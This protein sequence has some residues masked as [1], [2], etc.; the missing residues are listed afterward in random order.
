LEKSEW[1]EWEIRL[2]LSELFE[3]EGLNRGVRAGGSR[4]ELDET[5]K[6]GRIVHARE[7]LR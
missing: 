6:D 7:N 5:R 2:D 4:K 3:K 1:Q